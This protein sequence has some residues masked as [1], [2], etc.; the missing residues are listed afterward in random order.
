MKTWIW[1]VI[2]LALFFVGIGV[3]IGNVG[4]SYN[5]F[6]ESDL[7]VIQQSLQKEVNNGICTRAKY[8]NNKITLNCIDDLTKSGMIL[9][10]QRLE[11]D[12]LQIQTPL[13]FDVEFRSSGDRLID[14]YYDTIKNG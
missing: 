5:Q 8:E 12:I 13:R 14:V 1:I 4:E 3:L 10:V 2:G 6:T 7:Q 11:K 9:V